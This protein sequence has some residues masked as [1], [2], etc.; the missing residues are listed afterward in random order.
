[1][2]EL[3]MS[4]R[5]ARPVVNFLVERFFPSGLFFYGKGP[6]SAFEKVDAERGE[7]AIGYTAA[8]F[9]M[10]RCHEESADE[11]SVEAVGVTINGENIGDWRVTVSR[12]ALSQ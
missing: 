1:M 10:R 12:A 4:Q 8:L 3:S 2:S 6:L 7:K 9:L 5:L 11:L